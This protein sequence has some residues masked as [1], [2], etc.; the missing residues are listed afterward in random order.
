MI[1]VEGFEILFRLCSPSLLLF[2]TSSSSRSFLAISYS[3]L[4]WKWCR[5]RPSQAVPSLSLP[6]LFTPR[7]HGCMT[8]LELRMADIGM[9]LVAACRDVEYPAVGMGLSCLALGG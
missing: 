5:L 7:A 9:A 4:L 8:S 2:A 6:L 1:G 3:L